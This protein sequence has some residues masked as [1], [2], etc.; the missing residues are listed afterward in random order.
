MCSDENLLLVLYRGYLLDV[1]CPATCDNSVDVM[2]RWSCRGLISRSKPG[3]RLIP[4]EVGIIGAD[5][6]PGNNNSQRVQDWVDSCYVYR[7]RYLGLQ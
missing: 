3:A 5:I 2:F 4:P 6:I 1:L 7:P